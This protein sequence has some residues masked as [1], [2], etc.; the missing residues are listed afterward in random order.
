MEIESIK[1]VGAAN[2]GAASSYVPPVS[3]TSG[4]S[5]KVVNDTQKA[6][7][8]PSES[9]S[10]S[11]N[12][13]EVQNQAN[14]N[15]KVAK[16]TIDST[17]SETNSKI[18]MSKLKYHIDEETQRISIK[19]IDKDTDKVIREV[20]PEETLEAIKKIWEIAGIIVDEKR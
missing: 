18:K 16:S 9:N 12:Q 10:D 2:S 17:I 5:V 15:R 20:P 19:I 3:D 4:N 8:T 1:S 13:S 11:N 6:A 14:E 7:A